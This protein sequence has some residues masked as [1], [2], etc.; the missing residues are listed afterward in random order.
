[1]KHT[2]MFKLIKEIDSIPFNAPECADYYNEISKLFKR[3]LERE[4]YE[5]SQA[6]IVTG[7]QIGR[8]H[9]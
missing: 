5:F 2:P 9:V 4:A 1:M 7:K 6:Y 3:A 8:A